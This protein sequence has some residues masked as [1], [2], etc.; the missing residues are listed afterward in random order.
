MLGLKTRSQETLDSLQELMNPT[1]SFQKLRESIS[2]AG[3]AV[4]PYV[5]VTK[6]LQVTVN[7]I[8]TSEHVNRF[9]AKNHLV[10]IHCF[11]GMHLSDLI[12]IDEGNKNWVTR[13][14]GTPCV[15]LYKQQLIHT[16]IKKLLQV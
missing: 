5:Y 2:V 9:P 8:P 1:K 15:N 11:R 4:L 10:C 14:D 16:N 6:P 13:E 3:K 7:S 12:M